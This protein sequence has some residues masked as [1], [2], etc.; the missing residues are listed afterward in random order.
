MKYSIIII[1]LIFSFSCS[2]QLE[3]KP[4]TYSQLLTGK[5][6][7]TW[8]LSGLQLRENDRPLESYNLPPNNCG[9][10]DLYI[11]YANESKTFVIDEGPSKC[12]ESDPQIFVSDTW[13]LVNATATLEMVLPILI[14]FRYPY[15][16]KELTENRLVTEVYFADG[17]QSYRMI[18][19]L[20]D[21]E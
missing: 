21:E 12:N 6:S 3:I 9:F 18:F 4:L 2:E 7:K 11:F 8:R 10:D 19:T 5:T 17:I 14:P 16:V 15:I 20:V 13:S 1:L